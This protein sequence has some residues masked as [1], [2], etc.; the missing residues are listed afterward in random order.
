MYFEMLLAVAFIF[1]SR[2]LHT[3]THPYSIRVPPL[4]SPLFCVYPFCKVISLTPSHPSYRSFEP[5]GDDIK[6]STNTTLYLRKRI[7]FFFSLWVCGFCGTHGRC[8]GSWVSCVVSRHFFSSFSLHCKE[9]IDDLYNALYKFPIP[10]WWI[11]VYAC[12][13][14][15]FEDERLEAE[16]INEGGAHT[17]TK[18]SL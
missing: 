6:Y 2:D 3:H 12:F 7:F 8:D 11:K 4:F 5:E 10:C 1:P 16:E 17:H 9:A 14:T 18:K 15:F 13:L